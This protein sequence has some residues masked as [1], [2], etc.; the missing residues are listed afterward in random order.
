MKFENHLHY[1]CEI[2]LDN[3]ET[4]KVS[5]NWLHNNNL[6][7]WQGWECDAGY[8]RL[9]IDIDFNVHSALCYNEKL[10]NLFESWAVHDQPSICRRSRCTGCTDDLLIGKHEKSKD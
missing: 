7:N 10:G 1:N 2:E 3:G 6:D 8:R 5:A 4:Y 9:D